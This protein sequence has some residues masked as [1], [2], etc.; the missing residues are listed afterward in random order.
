M[1]AALIFSVLATTMLVGSGIA[2]ETTS[3]TI[4]YTLTN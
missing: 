3:P 1:K 2:A 4:T